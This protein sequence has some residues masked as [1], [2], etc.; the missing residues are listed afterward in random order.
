M[1][2]IVMSLLALVAG[3]DLAPKAPARSA[4]V[5]SAAWPFA[6][7]RIEVHPLSRLVTIGGQPGRIEAHILMRDRYG[8][9]TKGLGE[10]LLE[11]YSD[12]GP[13]TGVGEARQMMVWRFD[14]ANLEAN[15]EAYDNV[16]RTYRLNLADVPAATAAVGRATLRASLTTQGGKRLTAERRLSVVAGTGSGAGE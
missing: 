10:L 16:T 12:E 2:F 5:G 9:D 1:R 14:L 4:G 8:D 7:E 3:C 6:P 11:L 15:D 13:V